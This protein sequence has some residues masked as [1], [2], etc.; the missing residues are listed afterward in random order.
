MLHELGS[1]A[2]FMMPALRKNL[3]S[4]QIPAEVRS[5]GGGS[6]AHGDALVRVRVR[7]HWK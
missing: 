1:A 6:M 7:V 5:S 2:V 4:A 3:C